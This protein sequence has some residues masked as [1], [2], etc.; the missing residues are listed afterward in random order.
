MSPG[1]C[2]PDNGDSFSTMTKKSKILSGPNL[3]GQYAEQHLNNSLRLLIRRANK[4]REMI[5]TENMSDT[6]GG[7]NLQRKRK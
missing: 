2:Y 7:E 3:H 1:T 6:C 5:R 4:Q